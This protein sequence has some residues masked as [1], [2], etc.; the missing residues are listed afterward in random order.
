MAV[1]S[2]S[3]TTGPMSS[4]SSTPKPEQPADNPARRRQRLQHRCLI[5]KNNPVTLSASLLGKTPSEQ[6]E[7][8]RTGVLAAFG[9]LG[10]LFVGYLAWLILTPQFN[11]S[12]LLNG[13][14]PDG[15]EMAV[16]VLCLARSLLRQQ[17]RV[18]ALALGIGLLSWSIGDTLWTAQ[19]LGGAVP[20]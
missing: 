9:L 2:N 20:P 15:F 17:G 1:V 18:V 6:G 19:T 10:L 13:W 5:A 3:A 7:R 8:V 12:P 11:F 16:A 14:L 4:T